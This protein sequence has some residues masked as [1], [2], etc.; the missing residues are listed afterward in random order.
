MNANIGSKSY[1]T[2]KDECRIFN[3]RL[4]YSHYDGEATWAIATDLNEIE[5]RAKYSEFIR[6]YEPFI[7]LTMEQASAIV[8]YR[9]NERKHEK[10]M[11]AL[12]DAYAYE[13]GKLERFHPELVV[14]PFDDTTYDDLHEAVDKLPSPHR[15]RI[16]KR[17]FYG[18]T[19]IEIAEEEKA[20]KQAISKS[21]NKSLVLLKNYLQNG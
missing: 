21:I 1:S 8:K 15:E 20:T 4:E 19:I 5:L 2:F 10:R 14:S 7:I 18:M 12:G 17:F 6:E 11:A 13:D 16:I 3:L 9:S